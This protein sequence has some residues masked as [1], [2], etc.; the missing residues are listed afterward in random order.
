MAIDGLRQDKE[1]TT[2]ET[3]AYLPILD[4]V[5]SQQK[6]VVKNVSAMVHLSDGTLL[7]LTALN[8]IAVNKNGRYKLKAEAK[9]LRP[10]L[11]NFWF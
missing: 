10:W 6:I 1:V 3:E 5:L 9:L 4:W 2:L 7:P 8:L 11:L